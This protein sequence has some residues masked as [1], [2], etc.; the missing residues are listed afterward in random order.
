MKKVA[1]FLV[2]SGVVL[3]S[4]ADSSTQKILMDDVLFNQIIK[5]EQ[6]KKVSKEA[7]ESEVKKEVVAD[8]PPT[9]QTRK[10]IGMGMVYNTIYSMAM[11]KFMFNETFP[12][13]SGV[14]GGY[15]GCKLALFTRF[16]SWP[17]L[18]M[19][20]LVKPVGIVFSATAIAAVVSGLCGYTL[21]KYGMKNEE[22]FHDNKLIVNYQM[23]NISRDQMP[24][25]CAK[26]LA[27]FGA[28]TVSNLGGLV[29]YSWIL[30]KRYDLEQ[31]R[32]FKERAA[33]LASY[34]L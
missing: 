14:I 17:K 11:N 8:N 5:K 7:S 15:H 13:V 32:K 4:K 33:L 23:S 16:G 10:I 19:K 29:L 18:D 25:E 1:F 28:G 27:Y 2:L 9:K 21:G 6:T 22:S 3:S 20:D 31:D 26:V 34:K 12:I 30:K 24:M